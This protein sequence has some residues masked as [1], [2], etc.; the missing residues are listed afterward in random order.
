M[1]ARNELAD[2][3][4]ELLQLTQEEGAAIAAALWPAVVRIQARKAAL[5]HML[6]A[7]RGDQAATAS[8][9]GEAARIISLLARNGEALTA[10]LDRARARQKSIDQARQN[11]RRIQRS[12]LP[13]QKSL[14]WQSYS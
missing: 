7:A 8:L 12:Y 5:R 11:L 9:R 13:R 3:L 2:I 14:A 4:N 1:S 6:S 10:Q